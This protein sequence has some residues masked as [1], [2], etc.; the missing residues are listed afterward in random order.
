VIK[1]FDK[2]KK[3]NF[4]AFPISI[5]RWH[6]NDFLLTDPLVSRMHCTIDNINDDLTV[7]DLVSANRTILNDKIVCSDES[8]ADND[9]LIL[10]SNYIKLTIED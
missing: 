7:R 10:G 1:G 8:V 3:Q 4:S 5:G 2:G 9:I 6:D